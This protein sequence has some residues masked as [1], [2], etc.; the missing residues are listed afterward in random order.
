M[1]NQISN[2]P[3][4]VTQ[5]LETLTQIFTGNKGENIDFSNIAAWSE[6]LSNKDIAE[7]RNKIY[8]LSDLEYEFATDADA[9]DIVIDI[10]D[11]VKGISI[12]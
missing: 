11:T 7:M 8:R 2:L 6:D 10:I 5:A 9:Y 12:C 4:D 3:T 1:S